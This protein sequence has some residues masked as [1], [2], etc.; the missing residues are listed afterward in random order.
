MR[1]RPDS[2]RDTKRRV[3]GQRRDQEGNDN[4]TAV[5]TLGQ[6]LEPINF[7]REEA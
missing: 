3:T 5:I 6:R 1:G 2:V 7:G 4:E